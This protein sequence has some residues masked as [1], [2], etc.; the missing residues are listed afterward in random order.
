M[1][2]QHISDPWEKFEFNNALLKLFQ[3]KFAIK[4]SFALIISMDMSEDWEA[5]FRSNLP[6]SF[7]FSSSLMNSKEKLI[8]FNEF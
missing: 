7:K 4:F 6:N 5:L 1:L 3:R 2:Y 8:A